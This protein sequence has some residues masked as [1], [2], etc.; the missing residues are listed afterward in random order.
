MDMEAK[1]AGKI[2]QYFHEQNQ[3]DKG[4]SRK[5]RNLD[6]AMVS[7]FEKEIDKCL[8]N[9]GGFVSLRTFEPFAGARVW[10]LIRRKIYSNRN[11]E[12]SMDFYLQ[13]HLK[14]YRDNNW[15]KEYRDRD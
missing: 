15:I 3:N 7:N 13:C 11:P 12:E 14:G 1:S 4:Y 6:P 8:E 5:L 9:M 2:F 10:R